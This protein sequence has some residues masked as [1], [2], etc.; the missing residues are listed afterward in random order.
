MFIKVYKI[1]KHSLFIKD[2]ELNKGKSIAIH[3]L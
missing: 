3:M 2:P 1:Q